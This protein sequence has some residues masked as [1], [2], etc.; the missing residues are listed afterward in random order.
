MAKAICDILKEKK[1]VIVS[2]EY[3]PSGSAIT[4]EKQGEKIFQMILGWTADNRRIMALLSEKLRR[5]L[6]GTRLLSKRM[7]LTTD[8]E[9][10]TLKS[11]QKT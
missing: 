6:G 3:S 1:W 2:E 4:R 10:V 7:S 9:N 5:R 11:L 8:S